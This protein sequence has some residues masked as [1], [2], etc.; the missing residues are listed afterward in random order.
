MRRNSLVIVVGIYQRICEQLDQRLGGKESAHLKK[1]VLVLH[2]FSNS[3]HISRSGHQILVV[4]K[5]TFPFSSMISSGMWLSGKCFL[6]LE[7]TFASFGD[8][9]DC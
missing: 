7:V 8:Q 2:F 9:I 3:F 4:S 6:I 1:N 5:I